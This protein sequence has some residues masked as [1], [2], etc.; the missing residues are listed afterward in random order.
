MRRRSDTAVDA[1]ISSVPR[2]IKARERRARALEAN[3]STAAAFRGVNTISGNC[4][5]CARSVF[6]NST[7]TIKTAAKRWWVACR[8]CGPLMISKISRQEAIDDWNNGVKR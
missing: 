6:L 3:E 5:K 2:E 4:P 1:F 7:W 8:K